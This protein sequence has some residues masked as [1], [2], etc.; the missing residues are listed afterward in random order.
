MAPAISKRIARTRSNQFMPASFRK[1]LI[2]Y[3]RKSPCNARGERGLL[4]SSPPEDKVDS[5]GNHGD[6]QSDRQHDG[7]GLHVWTPFCGP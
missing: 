3:H 4:S 2:S 1:V 5:P 7:N 6:R